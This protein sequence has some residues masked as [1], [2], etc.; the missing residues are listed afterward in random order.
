VSLPAVS[1]PAVSLLSL[2]TPAVS[3]PAVSLP[4]VSLLSLTT[5]AVSL[6]AVS[7]PAVS[8]L[9]LTTPVVSLI[10]TSAPA[11][12]KAPSTNPLSTTLPLKIR[13]TSGTPETLVALVSDTSPPDPSVA[14]VIAALP[15]TGCGFLSRL[16]I[17]V[18]T[19][20]SPTG[21]SA[22]LADVSLPDAPGQPP[23]PGDPSGGSPAPPPASPS[24]SGGDSFSHGLPV[25][26]GPNSSLLG[27]WPS[28]RLSPEVPGYRPVR[29]IELVERPD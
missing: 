7:L 21:T 3:L 8:L 13:L 15:A 25:S 6:P 24:S 19:G 5:P 9:S 28:S 17:G 16:G 4:A 10:A 22:N 2:T 11:T 1:L 18:A 26:L 20:T 23:L 29:L 27:A 14:G 12:F